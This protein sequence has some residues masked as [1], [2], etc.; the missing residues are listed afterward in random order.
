M[1][2]KCKYV[3]TLKKNGVEYLMCSIDGGFCAYQRYCQTLGKVINSPGCT[4]CVAYKRE[5]EKEA[6]EDETS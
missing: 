3:N 4:E 6:A 5:T 2:Y 1:E